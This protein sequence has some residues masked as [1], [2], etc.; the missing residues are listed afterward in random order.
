[1]IK[2]QKN[3]CHKL[4][5]TDFNSLYYSLQ[6]IDHSFLVLHKVVGLIWL[7]DFFFISGEGNVSQKIKNSPLV[8]GSN[9]AATTSSSTGNLE[10]TSGNTGP[11]TSVSA[12]IN[13]SSNGISGNS[14]AEPSPHKRPTDPKR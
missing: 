3:H 13:A 7:H 14:S 10:N 8:S 1:M 5:I 2:F 6:L 11:T 9:Q 12:T 4:F